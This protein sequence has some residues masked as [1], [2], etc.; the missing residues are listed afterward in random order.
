MLG[1]NN[2]A[3]GL[4][5]LENAAELR[6][7]WLAIRLKI[8]Y[9]VFMAK[10]R[11]QEALAKTDLKEA[12]LKRFISYVQIDTQSNAAEADAGIIPSTEGQKKL[13]RLLEA[14]LKELGFDEVFVSE[15][16]YVCARLNATKAKEKT[17]SLCFLAHMDTSD[18]VSGKDVQVKISENYDGR[19][20]VLSSAPEGLA[21]DPELEPELL[22]CLGD[23]IIHTDGK[24]LL[25][26]D[27]KAGIAEIITALEYI[28][29]KNIPHGQIELIFSPDEETGH[30]MDKVPFDWIE[31]EFC[32]TLDGSHLG[33][34][35]YECFN[36]YKSDIRFIGKA[37]HT[38]TARGKLIN[39]LTMAAFYIGLLPR[40]EGPETTDGYEGFFTAMDLSGNIEEANL[41]VFI[42]DFETESMQNRLKRLE[43][44]AEA[45]EAHFPGSKVEIQHTE[46]YKNMKDA[47]L[48]KPEAMQLVK[49]ALDELDIEMISKPIRGG[50]DG[51]RLTEMG[52]PTPNIFTGGHSF[53]SRAEWA[54]LSQMIWATETIIHIIKN[55]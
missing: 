36:A 16:F 45:T 8:A 23:S 33:E 12:L 15:H 20:I 48:K 17:P 35:E 39:A 11:I 10:N 25:G 3:I 43:I 24:T 40:N 46:Q 30:G 42:R 13:A 32:Y 52:K 41:T 19:A 28:I 14:E 31:S 37:A 51:S 53:H 38:G 18:A 26:A 50:T 6:V 27:D 9:H 55:A 54:S 5:S 2:Q 7:K 4:G 49:K 21:L 47:L 34:V 1:E 44:F 29:E 22:D